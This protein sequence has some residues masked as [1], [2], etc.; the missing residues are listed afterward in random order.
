MT[1]NEFDVLDELYFVQPFNAIL[2]ETQLAESELK[3][4]LSGLLNKGW[5][6]CF[7][8]RQAEMPI[9]LSE[10]GNDLTSY[11]YLATKEGLLVHNGR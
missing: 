10:L 11:F 4:V 2:E 7:G 1:D 5:V 9:A 6:K 8:D 3:E